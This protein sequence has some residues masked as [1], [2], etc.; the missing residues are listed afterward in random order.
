MTAQQVNLY[1]PIF[2]R[3]KKVFSARTLLVAGAL[4]ALGLF[5]IY[6]VALVRT[7]QLERQLNQQQVALDASQSRLQALSQARAAQGADPALEQ[8]IERLRAERNF[9]LD[10]L[11]RLQR[12]QFGN[13]AGFSAYLRGLS[14]QHVPELWLTRVIV[15]N[16]G[17]ELMLEGSAMAPAI[18]PRYLQRLSH[19]SAFSGKEFRSVRMQRPEE[20]DWHIDFTLATAP[21]AQE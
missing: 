4:A 21:E 8:R 14:R 6:S 13:R 15:D 5:A 16:G 2:R 7:Q 10:M 11:D 17:T 3:E 12:N 18:V 9:K 1:Q 20:R 19:E